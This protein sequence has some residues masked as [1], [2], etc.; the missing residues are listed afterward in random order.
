MC[1]YDEKIF[2]D[3]DWRGKVAGPNAN[4]IQH[5]RK[6]CRELAVL[7]RCWKKSTGKLES[8]SKWNRPLRSFSQTE[9]PVRS[10]H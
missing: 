7:C 5:G 4:G 3:N 9:I 1:K 6:K 2:A 10:N 8:S